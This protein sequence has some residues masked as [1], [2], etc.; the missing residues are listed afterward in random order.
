MTTGTM[1]GM[2]TVTM[3][4]TKTTKGDDNVEVVKGDENTTRRNKDKNLKR[5]S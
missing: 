1:M 4:I 2:A 3:M 5:T